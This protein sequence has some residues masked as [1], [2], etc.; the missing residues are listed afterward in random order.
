MVVPPNKP[1]ENMK[2]GIA[3]AH[4]YYLLNNAKNPK[5]V[6]MECKILVHGI[7][8]YIKCIIFTYVHTYV[9]FSRDRGVSQGD[10]Y[11]VHTDVSGSRD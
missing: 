6:G 1:S 3:A 11:G 8:G 4:R 2:D 5:Y 7:G 10:G 9:N